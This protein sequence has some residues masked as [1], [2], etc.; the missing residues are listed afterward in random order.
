VTY[1]YPEGTYSL[2]REGAFWW[3]DGDGE[4]LPGNKNIIESTLQGL[5]PLIASDFARPRE[6]SMIDFN[7]PMVEITVSTLGEA[8][9]AITMKLVKKDAEFFYIHTAPDLVYIV[10][11]IF[12][13][14]LLRKMD[15]F[16][17]DGS[18]QET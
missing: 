1:T 6:I 4:R 5:A 12:V 2:V 17:A 14:G 10:K 9:A 13:D 7:A 15:D 3:V 16:V 8:D 11:K 18:T